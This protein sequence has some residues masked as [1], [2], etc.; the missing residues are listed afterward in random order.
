M[1]LVNVKLARAIWLVDS[2]DLN[3]HGIDMFPILDAIRSRYNFQVYPK[4]VE[5]A[6][7]YDSKGIV[8][9]NGSFAAT[10]SGRHTIIKATMY[11]D[12]IVVDS[13]L[14]TDFSEA[15]M[16]DALLFLS[17]Q[18]GLTYR[19]DMVH[20]K[21]YMNE[22]IVRVEKELYGAFASLAAVT[23]KLRQITGHEFKP[24]GLIFGLDPAAPHSRPVAFKFEREVGKP[25]S[26][27]RYFTSAP[28]RTS[29]HEELL[30]TLES[31]L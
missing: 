12:G 31:L 11:G 4:T 3:P 21:L 26:Q 28:M 2:R 30:R 1:T 6:N 22:M 8:F 14:S 24:S 17:T 15:F 27:H 7:E 10:G 29:Q 18:F 9:M 20:T 25:F 19:P 16:A 5:E 13:A 23:E